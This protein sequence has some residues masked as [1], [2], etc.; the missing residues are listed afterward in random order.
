MATD[1]A[2]RS[3]TNT[4]TTTVADTVTITQG[5][6]NLDVFNYDA[7]NYLYVRQDGQTAVAEA[8]N[9]SPVRPSSMRTIPASVNS[10][11]QIVVSIVGSG[12]KY[13]IEGVNSLYG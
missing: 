9:T 10:A 4:L 1:S 3:V 12:G 11:G 7:T 5:W 2:S 6:Q 13:T 8:D